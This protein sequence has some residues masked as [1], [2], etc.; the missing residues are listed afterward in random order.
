[1]IKQ[2]FLKAFIRYK[3]ELQRNTVKKKRENHGIKP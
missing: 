1:M 2:L 3:V